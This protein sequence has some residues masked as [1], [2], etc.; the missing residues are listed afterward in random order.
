MSTEDNKATTRRI[1]YVRPRA[2]WGS[3]LLVL[4]MLGLFVVAPGASAASPTPVAACGPITAP[5]SYQVTG[6]LVSVASTCITIS[7]SSVTL[8]VNSQTITCVNPSGFFG[9]CQVFGPGPVGIDVGPGVTDV[10]VMGP[11]TITGFDTGVRVSSSNA[12]V[13]GLTVTGPGPGVC[14]PGACF[15]P[16]SVGIEVNGTSGVNLLNNTESFHAD[17]IHMDDVT[18]PG[19][20]ASCVLNG[21]IVHDNFSDPIPCHGITLFDTTGYTVTGNM[22]SANG[23]NGFE[24]GGIYLVGAGT[25]GNTVVNNNSSNN[26]GFGI[27]ASGAFG[28]P[29]TGNNI[30]NNVAKGN[31]F[32]PPVYADLAEITGAGPNSWNKN[33]TCN[34]ETGTVPPG[35]CNPGE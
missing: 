12:L 5:G 28:V 35:V 30:V 13:T 25:T 8:D 29:V 32:S 11:G 3:I 15:R 6:P 18:C 21:N 34:T 9:S 27:A 33:N 19:G 7:A 2:V 23:E 24:N 22:I 4:M 1:F 17:G 20:D 16:D 10:A 14:T 31:T 26:L